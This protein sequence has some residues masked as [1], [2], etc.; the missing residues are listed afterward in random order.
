MSA[1]N[2]TQDCS[3]KTGSLV[4]IDTTPTDDIRVVASIH[5]FKVGK[6]IDLKIPK[7]STL[8]EILELV[9]PDRVLRRHAVIWIEDHLI[10][11]TNWH[12]V[13]P[14][15]GTTVTIRVVAHGG[16]GGK[17]PFRLLL[18]I[19]VIVASN[20]WGAALAGSLGLASGISVAGFSITASQIGSA[21]IGVVGNLLI[22]AI[23]P[24]RPPR[25]SGSGRSNVAES[26]T[27]SLSGSR[28]QANRFGPI[29][30]V[31][32]KY[33]Y[34]PNY[35]ADPFTEIVGSD[36]YLRM[37]FVWGHGPLLIEDILIGDT[38]IS[39][40]T[41]V[42]IVNRAGYAEDPSLSLYTKDVKENNISAV[43]TK[44]GGAVIRNTEPDVDEASVDIVF[45]Q[46]LSLFDD[47][48]IRQ[49]WS[50][51]F[52]IEYAPIGSTSFVGTG[53][54]FAGA[55]TT[56]SL[57]AESTSRLVESPYRPVYN[58]YIT[59]VNPHR[60]DMV[61]MNLYDGS[62]SVFSGPAVFEDDIAQPPVIPST[63]TPL[64]LVYRDT[65]AVITPD[66]VTDKRVEPYS[67]SGEFLVTTNG[68]DTL[69]IAPGNLR[70]GRQTATQKTSEVYRISQRI[71]FPTKG[72]YQIRVTRFTDDSTLEKIFDK[73]TFATLRSI[74]NQLPF[75]PKGLATTEIRMKATDQLN[76][77]V[78]ELSGLI[79]SILPDY[80]E[81][82]DEWVLR[83][84]QNLASLSLGILRGP[85][86]A[87]PNAAETI[88]FDSFEYWHT[89][90]KGKNYTFNMVRDFV[91]SVW[92]AFADVAAAGIAAPTRVDGKWGV[93]ID[94]NK[95]VPVQHF[96]PRNSYNFSFERIYPDKVHAWRI[97]FQNEN[98]NY[99]R[100]EIIVYDDGYS[101]ANAEIFAQMNFDGVTNPDQIYR[102]GRHRIAELR[103]RPE[104]YT[105]STDFEF[106]VC[107]RGDLCLLTHDVLSVG[108]NSGRI[109]E[110]VLNVDGDTIG[111]VID[112]PVDMEL[113][114]VYGVS[115]RTRGTVRVIRQLQPQV[116]IDIH[117]VI[118]TAPVL[119]AQSPEVGDLYAFGEYGLETLEVLVKS[120]QPGRDLTAVIRLVPLS[121]AIYDVANA[122]IPPFQ[123]NITQ[124][125]GALIPFVISIRS[126]ESVLREL[127]SG[128]LQPQILITLGRPSELTLNP[129]QFVEVQ[130]RVKDEEPVFTSYTTQKF[131][132]L[133]ISL[134]NVEQGTTYEMK[135]R[136]I[137]ASGPGTFGP[138][139][140]HTVIGMANPPSDVMTLAL[141]GEWLRWDYVKPKD[142]KGF[143]VKSGATI[144]TTWERGVQ[145]HS[146]FL[147]RGELNLENVQ[148]GVRKFM[149]KAVD[150]ANNESINEASINRFYGDVLVDNLLE[151]I[152]YTALG[153][154]GTI[155]G[156]SVV[157]TDIVADDLNLYLPT[158]TDSYLFYGSDPYLPNQFADVVYETSNLFIDSTRFPARLTIAKSILGDY[159]LEYIVSIDDPYL[160]IGGD[161]YLPV[162]GDPY[163]PVVYDEGDWRVFPQYLNVLENDVYRFR[164]TLYG[165]EDSGEIQAF[166]VI[167]D[168]EDEVEIISNF[169]L[170]AVGSRL[171]LTKV[172]RAIKI[173]NMNLLPG[174]TAVNV[175]PLD[176]NP[177]LGPL[178]KAFDATNTGVTA[179]INAHII[180]VKG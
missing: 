63:H 166:A 81:G 169:A 153:Y 92:E 115:I 47:E 58:Y 95:T 46:G 98:A 84:T 155:V 85:G 29:P 21:I 178:V 90:S 7:G 39:N 161:P 78:D 93:L 36:Q 125:A 101:A 22:S 177:T 180:G 138:L 4:S 8:Q 168:V 30:V 97:P 35:G 134:P 2:L 66:M 91:S 53:M 6:V 48:G 10:P 75:D 131:D 139:Y 68:T 108:L 160:P 51:T 42:E 114:K 112:T 144:D 57:L 59:V 15:G 100:D 154:P 25:L 141:E 80:D 107:T 151:T 146:G 14:N 170:L 129:V 77:V 9:Q 133:S 49:F 143:I 106:L 175:E 122:P 89:Q 128:L 79:T 41:D 158:G 56:P 64:A 111:L 28:N 145:I 117:T 88:D 87:R 105:L 20:V 54:T 71:A 103:L 55:R 167:I 109:K 60:Y 137:N 24:I 1:M 136:Y 147:S 69:S 86:N 5:P 123:S 164:V 113:T 124:P 165:G 162:G 172:Y 148:R 149:V 104:S 3:G 163:L 16:G 96:T 94:E 34:K 179:T 176:Y 83:P 121:R 120:I 110:L 52:D 156:G 17:S 82:L 62:I 50:V 118:F 67:T 99:E 44:A 73:M 33:R 70:S 74:K 142:F 37:V 102:L 32:G 150:L 135:M 116:G 65:S 12:L 119:A 157:S 174:S 152:D 130:Y 126:D 159:N 76:N 26:A 140:T 40:Y 27:L 11:H 61:A 18:T 173:V 72:Q 127:P 31:L 19:A 23:A 43:V 171:P 45:P 13:R 132:T 38:P